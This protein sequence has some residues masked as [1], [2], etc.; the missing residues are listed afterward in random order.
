MAACSN[1]MKDISRFDRKTPPDQTLKDARIWRSEYGRLQLELEAPSI[2]QYRNPDT[3]THYPD[4]VNLRFYDND[5]NLK[6]S[7]RAN[8]ATSYDER[9]ILY[10]RDSVVIID[11]ATGDTIYLEDITWKSSEDVI[12]SNRPVR[13]VN[14]SRVTFGDGFVSNAKFTNLRVTRQRGTIEFQE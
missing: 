5:L 7:I 9:D 6:T 11:Y 3:R 12:Y 4:G 1:D 8:K 10:A 14:G 13:A 2:V